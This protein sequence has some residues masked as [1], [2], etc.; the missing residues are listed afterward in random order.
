MLR[1][2]GKA[3]DLKLMI[4]LGMKAHVS[5]CMSKDS[6]TSE[7]TSMMKV[8]LRH[9]TYC[10]N[11]EVATIHGFG[12]M[13]AGARMMEEYD[14]NIISGFD[15][16]KSTLKLIGGFPAIS[17]AYQLGPGEP[18]ELVYPKC[19]EG[20]HMVE[21]LKK[22]PAAY[23]TY[24][25]KTVIPDTDF[26][27]RMVIATCD[28][29]CALKVEA[30]EWDQETKTLST[31]AEIADKD[32]ANFDNAPWWEN[33]FDL[34]TL[35]L[36][37]TR[38]GQRQSLKI[39]DLEQEGS[40]KTIQNKKKRKPAVSFHVD[41]EDDSASSSS[42]GLLSS[43]NHTNEATGKTPS[44]IHASTSVISPMEVGDGSSSAGS[45]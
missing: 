10:A 26:T 5:K 24:S 11:M 1:L 40:T 37:E 4:P 42:P 38:K 17:E 8:A 21:Q 29:A 13:C 2:I 20:H 32:R 44:K 31:P 18:V 28:T 9:G 36:D 45:G 23:L 22:N 27:W 35:A 14:Y 3:K 30:C 16:I 34:S 39:F 6:T 33:A 12:N 25:L 15:F 7:N 19:A 41:D 43:N